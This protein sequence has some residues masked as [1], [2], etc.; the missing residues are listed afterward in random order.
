[1]TPLETITIRS[2][3]ARVV[4][5]PDRGGIATRFIVADRPIFYLD[6]STLVDRSKNVRGG[7]PVLFPSP[8]KLEGDR[9]TRDGRSGSMSQ[10]GLLR[11]L[12]WEVLA[13]TESAVTL[14]VRS[15]DATRAAYPWDFVVTYRY[16]LSGT[17]LRIEQRF[18]NPGPTPM[19]FAAGFHPYFAVP[20]GD[21]AKT[22]LPTKA[23]RAWDNAKKETIS[24]EAPI[25]LTQAEVDLS[26]IDHGDC[27]M[28]LGLVDGSRAQVRAS[29]E[30]TRWVVWTVE[31]KDFVCVE[32]WTA[33]GDAL[34][35]GEALLVAPPGGSVDLWTEIAFFRP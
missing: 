28:T 2:D 12:P 25:D 29:A 1:M 24:L 10:H 27:Q 6:E 8:G 5:A 21:K 22:S 31:G 14:A 3:A 15:T 26:L 32:P 19:P 33:P 34:N 11:N 35:T 9:F 30:F 7:N 13:Q 23:R 20:Q 16:V 18:E 4:L 17:T